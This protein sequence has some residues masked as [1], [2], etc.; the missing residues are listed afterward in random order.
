MHGVTMKIRVSELFI[1]LERI[2]EHEVNSI[3]V[4]VYNADETALTTFY[5]GGVMEKCS[6]AYFG[7]SEVQREE[8]LQQQQQLSAVSALLFAVRLLERIQNGNNMRR[9]KR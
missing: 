8:T 3:R 5:G 4:Y 2:V 7:Q 1:L 9:L 6:I